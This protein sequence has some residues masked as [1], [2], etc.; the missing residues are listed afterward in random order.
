MA[1]AAAAATAMAAAAAAM[2]AAATTD[3]KPA[4]GKAK[5]P[6]AVPFQSRVVELTTGTADWQMP[7]SYGKHSAGKAPLCKE[8]EELGWIKASEGSWLGSNKSDWPP[9]TTEFTITFDVTS[10]E[11]AHFELQY[12]ADNK[13]EGVTLNSRSLSVPSTY[14]QDYKTLSKL[15]VQ[16]GSGLFKKGPNTLSVQVS[17]NGHAENPMGFYARGSLVE[18]EVAEGEREEPHREN[19]KEATRKAGTTQTSDGEVLR[20]PVVVRV[21]VR[22]SGSISG[23]GSVK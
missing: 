20:R 15:A 10:P 22:V 12:A 2:A 9:G 23:S 17:N 1:E 8:H 14:G 16:T 13:V 4:D 3:A 7:R 21:R 11:N 19:E 6:A 5:R 18:D